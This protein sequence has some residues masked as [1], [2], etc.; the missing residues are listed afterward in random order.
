M[1]NIL[2]RYFNVQSEDELVARKGR[3]F[4]FIV[5]VTSVAVLLTLFKDIVFGPTVP[6][7][8]ALE[9]LSLIIFGVLYWYTRRGHRWPPQVFLTFMALLMPYAFRQDF[10][11][12]KVLALAAPVV[13]VPLVASSRLCIPVAAAE[14]V[15][16]YVI[17]FASDYPS[18]DPIAVIVLGVLGMVSWLSSSIIENALREAQHHA[19]T[20]AETNRELQ[21]SRALLED[22]T[23]ELERRADYLETSAEVSRS[24]TSILDTEQLIQQTVEL[25]RERFGLYYVGLFLL[26]ATGQWA[27]LRAGTGEAGRAMLARGHRL[28]VGEG[29]IGWCIANAQA[30]IALDAS[31]DMV[32]VAP[33]ELSETRSEAAL[34]LRSRGRVIGAL[35]I[36]S[37]QPGVFDQNVVVV[38]QTMADQVAV[39]IDNA[40]LFAEAQE[41]L[42][43]TRRAYG[44]LSREAWA[45]LLHAQPDLAYRSDER[46]VTKAESIWRPEMERALQEGRTITLDGDQSRSQDGGTDTEAK[47]PLAVPIKVRGHVI[48]V[49]DTYKPDHAG[50]WTPEEVSL[51]ETLADQL[52]MALESARLLDETRRHAT[53]DQMLADIT[54]RVRASMNPET[55]LRTAV[56]ELGLALGADRASVHLNVGRGLGTSAPQDQDSEQ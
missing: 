51:L 31:E 8:L 42:E 6:E 27:V 40:R 46:G 11:N 3:L 47:R 55:I 44:E 1:K 35:T 54:A 52:G 34:P 25:I 32:R 12:P 5:L 15:M 22:Y 43:A 30:R 7:Y 49:L 16:L 50:E 4:N 38:L 20:L 28:K 48:G 56:R 23:R 24:A 19:R 45:E 26:D 17:S 13:M 21:A 9:I 14:V 41:A 2:D 36:Q 37:D 10:Q 29:M 53:R 33:P 18:P 39:A